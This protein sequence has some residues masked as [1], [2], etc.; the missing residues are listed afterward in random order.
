[1]GGGK[2]LKN[3]K[4]FLMGSLFS[5]QQSTPREELHPLHYVLMYFSLFQRFTGSFFCYV[6]GIY[7]KFCF[8]K[9]RQLLQ[10]P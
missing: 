7:R 10:I 1:M 5:L 3:R 6:C 9:I 8:R 2:E 4:A